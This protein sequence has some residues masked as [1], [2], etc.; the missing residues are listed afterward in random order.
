[1]TFKDFD[2]HVVDTLNTGT[3]LFSIIDHHGNDYA[4]VFRQDQDKEGE[5]QVELLNFRTTTNGKHTFTQ[6][7][8]GYDVFSV[9]VN[10]VVHRSTGMSLMVKNGCLVVAEG[11]IV[12]KLEDGT[13]NYYIDF[14][15]GHLQVAIVAGRNP[16]ISFKGYNCYLQDTV[17]QR[18]QGELTFAS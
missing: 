16:V 18:A 15:N 14:H 7:I 13:T 12:E 1:M 2:L 6:H 11:I 10:Y 8:T 4:F 3:V 17:V 9:S 5:L